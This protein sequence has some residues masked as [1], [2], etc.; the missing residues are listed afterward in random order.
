MTNTHSKSF[1]KPTSLRTQTSR[2]TKSDQVP[3]RSTLPMAKTRNYTHTHSPNHLPTPMYGISVFNLSIPRKYNLRHHY[4]QQYQTSRITSPITPFSET[5]VLPRLP[6]HL[7][8][9]RHASKGLLIPITRSR[10]ISH[11]SLAPGPIIRI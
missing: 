9:Y 6:P 10:S 1:S 2:G 3:H 11:T 8:I 7:Q 5:V 4:S